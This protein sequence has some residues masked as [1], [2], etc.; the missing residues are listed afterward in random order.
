MIRP[1]S[2]PKPVQMAW[3]ITPPIIT[4]MRFSRAARIIVVICERSPH[5]ATKVIVKA[6]MK[7]LKRTLKAPALAF[8]APPTSGSVTAV[9]LLSLFTYFVNMEKM[10]KIN[11]AP[12]WRYS[13][14]KF[15]QFFLAKERKRNETNEKETES[16]FG[17]PW[18][19]SGVVY[20]RAMNSCWIDN[21]NV[22]WPPSDL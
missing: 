14:D 22:E 10:L 17:W 15:S 16:Y 18:N 4:P 7:I 3:P 5:S 21:Y 19:C 1:P 6:C 20:I 9:L 12:L 13:S 8:F 2:T 11:K